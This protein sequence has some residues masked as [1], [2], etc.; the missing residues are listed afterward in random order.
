LLTHSK[1]GQMLEKYKSRILPLDPALLFWIKR[2]SVL[3]I[4]VRASRYDI[5]VS[6]VQYL[7]VIRNVM[8]YASATI[9]TLIKKVFAIFPVH[10]PTI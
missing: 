6:M 5:V 8:I 4:A 10:I 3:L 2:R 9:V 7:E 1:N